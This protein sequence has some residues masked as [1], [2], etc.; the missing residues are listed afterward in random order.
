[1]TISLIVAAS[2]NNIIGKNN[3]LLWHL[4]ADLRY[5]KNT[6]WAMPAVMGRNTYESLGNKPL[7]G[8]FNFVVTRQEDWDPHSRKVKLASTLDRA[9]ELTKET[10]CKET[11]ILGGGQLYASSM[12]IANKIYI[13]RVHVVLEGDTR[14]PEINPQEWKMISNLDFPED[15][16]HAYP[17]SFQ[18]WTKK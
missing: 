10:D 9:I 14:F 2:T 1:M 11:F 6:T 15:A 13:T 3:K 17:Y 16:T 7:N 12:S 4:P 18:I 8:R 5:F